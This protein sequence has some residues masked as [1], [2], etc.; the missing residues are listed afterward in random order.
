MY[1]QEFQI[2]VVAERPKKSWRSMLAALA[3]FALAADASAG[4]DVECSE[5][6][7]CPLYSDARQPVAKGQIL[8][9]RGQYGAWSQIPGV[10][11]EPE[12]EMPPTLPSGTDYPELQTNDYKV[13]N[14]K[15]WKP[16]QNSMQD[17]ASLY[18]MPGASNSV[19][20]TESNLKSKERLAMLQAAGLLRE[21]RAYDSALGQVKRER[22][23]A[24]LVQLAAQAR[25]QAQADAE[26]TERAQARRHKEATWEALS[27]RGNA[28]MDVPQWQGSQAPFSALQTSVTPEPEDPPAEV[29]QETIDNLPKNFPKW[30]LQQAV[31]VLNGQAALP[32]EGTSSATD[33]EVGNVE[34]VNDGFEELWR[35][36]E[37]TVDKIQLL[38]KNDP[39][40]MHWVFAFISIFIWMKLILLTGYFYYDIKE[41]PTPRDP[42]ARAMPIG[43]WYYG[44]FKCGEKPAMTVFTFCCS[45][46][47]WADTIR[48]A[49]LWTF[50]PAL[51]VYST[52]YTWSWAAYYIPAPILLGICVYY[53][54]KIREEFQIP[55]CTLATILEDTC[56]HIWCN[57]CAIVQ[58]A[59]QLEQ[60][61]KTGDVPR[62]VFP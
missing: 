14:Y 35:I 2:V 3:L 40:I 44:L 34:S 10:E 46:V 6:S 26:A 52:I 48:M 7:G 24:E 39:D 19:E 27:R 9:Q 33:P 11:A 36:G 56:T 5:V 16:Y 53:R 51:F 60:A 43:V 18:S 41:Y 25:V 21:A 61:Y 28:S 49:G 58:E 62:P 23:R 50:W 54:Q 22:H 59:R 31:E 4:S 55:N 47:R 17:A 12:L 42:Q 15:V 20:A 45:P 8:L 32:S 1:T 57:C 13:D 37:N 38:R 29:L 30:R